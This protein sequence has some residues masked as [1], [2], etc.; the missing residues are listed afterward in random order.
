MSQRPGNPRSSLLGYIKLALTYIKVPG[1]HLA[2]TLGRNEPF[3]GCF[4]RHT[5]RMMSILAMIL[6]DQRRKSDLCTR[7]LSYS[8]LTS[9]DVQP[10]HANHYQLMMLSLLV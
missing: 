8:L 7:V 9:A 2:R 4:R 1:D 3:L 5:G 6:L 10:Q